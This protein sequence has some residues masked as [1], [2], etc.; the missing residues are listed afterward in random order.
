MGDFLGATICILEVAIY[1]AICAETDRANPSALL[2]LA[3]VLMLP[4]LYGAWRRKFDAGPTEP[5]EC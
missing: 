1:L 3:I 5:Q 2:R 4:Q